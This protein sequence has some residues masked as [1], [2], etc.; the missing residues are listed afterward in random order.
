M[1]APA[2]G[3]PEDK[4]E[5]AGKDEIAMVQMG[6]EAREQGA[7]DD[8]YDQ[9]FRQLKREAGWKTCLI[10]FLAITSIILFCSTIFALLDSAKYKGFMD[11]DCD[12]RGSPYVPYVPQPPPPAPAT[13]IVLSACNNQGY[14]FDGASEC[15]C[16]PCFSGPAC[17]HYVGDG[18]CVIDVN[19]GSPDIFTEYWA[20]NPMASTVKMTH[21]LAYR[22]LRVWQRLEAA[23]RAVHR[24]AGNA[25]TE[26]KYL[27]FGDGATPLI[28]VAQMAERGEETQGTC[29]ASGAS[30]TYQCAHAHIWAQ[31]PYYSGY[32]PVV[33]P[34]VLEFVG[35]QQETAQLDNETTVIEFITTPNNPDGDIRERK[36]TDRTAVWDLA[37]YWP[38][39]TAMTGP[40]DVQDDDFQLFTLSKL[41]GHASARVG[42]A[43]VSDKED[44]R[45]MQAYIRKSTLCSAFTQ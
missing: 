44:W 20:Q 12:S 10:I 6:A 39:Y 1:A 32:N 14:L 28:T 19:S 9:K 25:D 43:W 35:E 3:E 5:G 33:Y 7:L 29:V 21:H 30:G 2:A 38:M 11:K 24:L 27:V 37:Y 36:L 31:K 8:E 17:E 18:E 26:G 23:V 42:W 16:F 22:P 15:E 45:R 41:T 4:A 40:P 13:D 34:E